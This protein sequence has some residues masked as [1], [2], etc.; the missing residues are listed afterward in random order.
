M[1]EKTSIRF[2]NN[3]KVRARYNYEYNKWFFS[4]SDIISSLIKTNNA[5]KY[6]NAF[7][8]RHISINEYVKKIK[9]TADDGKIY[10]TDTLDELGVKLL[11][12]YLK[13][14]DTD[15]FYKWIKGLNN[16]EDELSRLKAYELYDNGLLL[17]LDAGKIS[18]LIE[19]HKY[20]FDGIYDFAGIIRNK[21][22][23][24]GNFAFANQMY[25]PEI[26][27]KIENMKDLTFDEIIDKYIEINIAHPFMEGNGRSMRIWLD[28]LLI[29][30][31]NRC[32]D[33]SKIDKNS[34]LKLMEESVINDKPIKDLLK[35]ALIDY[36]NDREV[37]IKGIDYSYYYEEIE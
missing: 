25:L 23:K 37:F 4:A 5:R 24:K 34:Y 10:L 31:L 19:I 14:S 16:K 20:L 30:R 21:N 11:L 15:Y 36:T 27:M 28:L 17:K 33:W 12:S 22:I 7:K 3:Q 35:S 18:S 2:F 9:L 26:L 29:K 32:I 1:V 8:R 13:T 6:W